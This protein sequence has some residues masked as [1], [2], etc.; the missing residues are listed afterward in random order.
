MDDDQKGNVPGNNN[1]QEGYSS[2]REAR[3]RRIEERRAARRGRYGSRWIGGAVLIALGIILLL[4]SLGSFYLENWWALFILIPAIGAFGNAARHEIV[5]H[6]TAHIADGLVE[7]LLPH[8]F[9]A[10]VENDLALIVHDV[11]ELQ[12]VLANVEVA[13]FHLGLPLFKRFVDPGVDNRLALFQAKTAQ[14]AIHAI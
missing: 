5:D 8:E 6:L 12:Q 3:W 13:G 1:A 9:D 4:S 7:V 2:R 14:H 11:V 10:L